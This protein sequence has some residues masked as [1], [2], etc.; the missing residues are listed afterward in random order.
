MRRSTR[1]LLATA[2]LAVSR[3]TIL[4]QVGSSTD[5]LTGRVMGPT[6]KALPGARVEATSI[7]T[8]VTRSRATDAQGRYTILFPDGGGQY[9]VTARMLGLSPQ[10]ATIARQADEDRLVRDFALSTAPATLEAVTINA[11]QTPAR[12][13]RPEPGSTERVLT[14]EQLQRLPIDPS[15]PNA[16]ALLQPGVVGIAGTDTTA[17]G[18]SV[19]GQRVDQN[20]VTLD[21]LTFGGVGVPPEAVRST[22]IITNTYDVA[23]GQF[24]GGQVATT[25]RGGTNQVTG[26]FTYALRDPHLEFEGDT[27][28][29]QSLSAGFTQNQLSGGIGGPVKKDRLFY[30]GAFQLRR[31]SDPLQVLTSVAPGTL[32]RLGTSP[33]SAMRFRHLVDSAGVPLTV[34]AVPDDRLQDNGTVITRIDWHVNDDHSLM[35]RGNW[36]GALQDA[37]GAS[38]FALPSHAGEQHSGGGGGMLTLSSIFG[39][40][41]NEGRAYYSGDDR[42]TEPYLST[43]EGRV[44]VASELPDGAVGVSTLAFG[45]NTGMPTEG[46]T[47]QLEATDELSWL[48]EGGAH[49]FKL[50]GLLNLSGFSTAAQT[51]RDGSFSYNSL[52]DL[53]ANRPAEFRRSLRATNRNGG[54]WNGAVYLG[55]TWRDSRALQVTYGLRLEG[56]AYRGLPAYNPAIDTAFGHRTDLLPRDARL[57][58]RVGFTWQLGTAE[59]RQRRDSAGGQGDRGGGAQRRENFGGRG[60][61]GGAGAFGAQ[62][63]GSFAPTTIVRGGFGEFRGRAPTQLF[64]SAIDATGLPG[65]ERLLVCIGGAVPAPDWTSYEADPSTIP[66]QCAGPATPVTSG[67]RS[68]VTVFD[69]AFSS[70]RS[71]R[72]SLGA[73]HRLGDRY[74]VS[75]DYTFALGTSL[76]GLRDL[77]LAA[78]PQFTLANEGG[79]PVFAPASTIFPTTGAVSLF[80]SRRV[81]AYGQVIEVSSR[82]HSH[83]HLLTLGVNGVSTRNMLWNI[84]YTFM[85][86]RDQTGFSPGSFGGGGFGGPGGGLGTVGAEDPNALEWG[87]SDL[88]RRHSFVGTLNWL[89]R[90]WVDVTG[91]LHV[92]SGQ[93]YSPRVASDINGDGSRNDRAFVFDPANPGIAGDT[94]LVN[95]MRRLLADGSD[96]ARSC[97]ESQLGTIASRNSCYSDWSASLD[98]QANFR[99]WMGASLQRRVSI[100]LV[101]INP[102]AG[103]DQ[104]LHGTAN[105][106]GW[107]QSSRPDATLLYVRGFD[108]ASSRYVYQV[109][110]RFGDNVSARTAFRTPF[111]LGLQA[112]MQVGPDRQREMLQGMLAALNNRGGGATGGFDFRAILDRI[113]PNPGRF[114]IG[115]RDSLKLTDLQAVR[116]QLIDDSLKV[117]KDQLLDSLTEKVRTGAEGRSDAASVFQLVQPLLQQGRSVYLAAIESTKQVLTPE[118]WNMLPDSFRNPAL[119]RGPG[120]RRG[121]PARPRPT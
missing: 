19:A 65:G 53:E 31:R 41:L 24:T 97:L 71:E 18:F 77:N 106:H 104:L 43:P 75:L 29:A 98:F 73:T 8:G 27:S 72:A 66:T 109:N 79:R 56:S 44:R 94:A 17:A 69:P 117:K 90:P 88:E 85:R 87:V 59:Q 12:G 105:L 51:N 60:G 107:G 9:R 55:D 119:Q 57:S 22:R 84:S 64:Q 61:G 80:A 3:T 81:P 11:R 70:P 34:P 35:F 120:G 110:E 118:Q 101:A 68:N 25:T 5:I 99:P 46:T 82:L 121:A 39:N 108:P 114:V 36:Q 32:A 1:V 42:N 67:Q 92:T 48:S 26:T 74:G 76:Y 2:M 83:S 47:N 16:L 45:G 113:A 13:E 30:F 54:A 23:R 28:V 6:G 93:P 49:R 89:A 103:V 116:L 112:R 38:A 102:L 95:G 100:S 15:D 7:E 14:G 4:A 96:R 78:T 63:G 33:D 111:M 10:S 37:F 21:G 40:V 50:G 58:P 62:G 86:S 52:A 91:V 115:M 20:Q